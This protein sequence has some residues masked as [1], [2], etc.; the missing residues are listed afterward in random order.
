[1]HLR[2][3]NDLL[4]CFPSGIGGTTA[5][6]LYAYQHVH[7]LFLQISIRDG[8]LQL[9]VF[10]WCIF[11]F[12]KTLIHNVSDAFCPKSQTFDPRPAIAALCGFL[13]SGLLNSHLESSKIIMAFALFLG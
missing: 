4:K 3:A 5:P 11:S 9:A 8:I 10:F 12:S 7:N 13:G 6:Y 2:R 1:M